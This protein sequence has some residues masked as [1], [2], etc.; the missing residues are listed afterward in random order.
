[1]KELWKDIKGYENLYRISNFGRIISL[2]R[3]LRKKDRW[4]NVINYKLKGKEIKSSLNNKGYSII[5]LYKNKKSKTFLLHRLVAEAFIPNP[6]GLLEI[7]HKDENKDNNC[8]DN[9]EWCTRKQNNNYGIQSKDGRRSTSKFRMKKV[10]Q[11]DHNGNLINVFDGIRLAEEK[12]GIANQNICKCCQGK[13]ETAGG[14]V[15]KYYEDDSDC[16]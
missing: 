10:C 3:I 5:R 13:V 6:K 12:T 1:M 4:G 7:N 16:K 15:W 9:L 14:Y 11:Y 2:D 8:V